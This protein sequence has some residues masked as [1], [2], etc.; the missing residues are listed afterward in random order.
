MSSLP[1]VNSPLLSISDL[2]CERDSRVLYQSLNIT[3]EAGDLWHVKGRNGAGKTTF[4]RQLAGLHPVD[5]GEISLLNN[6][7]RVIY[8]GHKLGLKEQLTADENLTWLAGLNGSSTQQQR[9]IALERV[10]LRGYEESVV[11]QLS[12]GQKRRVALARLHLCKADIWLLDEP[13]TSIDQQGIADEQAWL[14]K[15]TLAGGAVLMTSHQDIT[16]AQVKVLDL[17][18]WALQCSTNEHGDIV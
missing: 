3:I 18:H 15:H 1:P 6:N 10:G 12:A 4:L 17:S 2:A 5:E 7:A 16:L 9:Y 8:I 14:N 11:A 13:F